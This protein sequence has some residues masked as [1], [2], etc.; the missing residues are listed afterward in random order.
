MTKQTSYDLSLHLEKIDDLFVDPDT[1]PLENPHLR[2]SG[3]QTLLDELHTRSPDAAIHLTLYLPGDQITPE[4][5]ER[6]KDAIRRYC[7]FQ[8]ENNEREVENTRYS[9]QR[10][11]RVGLVGMAIFLL[12]STICYVVANKASNYLILGIAAVMATFFSVA[13]WVIIWGPVDTLVYGWR[14]IW[15]QA[16][17]YRSIADAQ[18]TFRAEP[19]NSQP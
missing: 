9:G 3:M 1:N 10:A 15:R 4:L 18:L 5:E 12:L 19:A 6:T 2:V 17:Q 13:S 11:F 16:R 7:E 14:T 8:I